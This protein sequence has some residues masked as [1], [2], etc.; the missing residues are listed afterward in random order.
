MDN[1]KEKVFIWAEQYLKLPA[2]TV[3]GVYFGTDEEGYSCCSGWASSG[4][5]VT[6]SVPLTGRQR[7]PRYKDEFISLDG[8]S[9]DSL[10]CAIL[11]LEQ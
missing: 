5:Y 1:V 4:V 11:E 9:L 10:I 6:H 8:E 7:K 2:G 3:S